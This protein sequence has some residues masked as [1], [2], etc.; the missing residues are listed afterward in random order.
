MNQRRAFGLYL[1][2]AGESSRNVVQLSD[3]S[4]V[5]RDVDSHQSELF[6]AAAYIY[7]ELHVRVFMCRFEKPIALVSIIGRLIKIFIH[8]AVV[9]LGATIIYDLSLS[10]SFSIWPFDDSGD[11]TFEL[12]ISARCLEKVYSRLQ[13]V[14]KVR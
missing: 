4:F 12:I 3:L 1:F 8:V 2:V 5:M 9:T 13:V 6:A 10:Y 11:D 7:F 14:K